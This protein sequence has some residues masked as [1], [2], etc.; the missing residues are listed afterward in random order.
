[1]RLKEPKAWRLLL[2]AAAVTLLALSV[3]CLGAPPAPRSWRF[4]CGTESSAVAK[5]YRRLT[6]A[7]LYSP[8]T[9]FGW[10]K[11]RPAGA[12]VRDLPDLKSFLLYPY[13]IESLDDLNRDSVVST[14]DLTF[15]ID[16]PPGTYRVRL[17]LGDMSRALGSI[18]VTVNGETAAEHVAAWTPGTRGPGNHRRILMDPY[19]WRSEVRHTVHAKQGFIRIEL[20]K[21]QSYYDR[22]LAGQERHEA[23]WNPNWRA[24]YARV[25]VTAPPYFFIGWPFVHHSVMAIEVVP[26]RPA[27]IVKRDGRLDLARTVASPALGEALAAFNGGRYE[28]ALRR[29]EGATEAPARVPRAILELWLAGRLE[30]EDERELV[31]KALA[32]LDPHCDRHP[33]ENGAAEI[34]SDARTFERALRMHRTRGELGKNHFVENAKAIGLWWLVRD[35]SP[36]FDK[37]QLYIARAAHMLLPYFPTRG[38][39]REILRRVE[40]KYPSNRYVRYLLHHQWEPYGDGSRFDDWRMTDYGPKLEGAPAWVRALYPAWAGML[41]WAEWFLGFKQ[42]PDGSIGGG[43]GD[44]VE[45]IGSFGYLGFTSRGVSDLTL[46]GTRKL[47]EGVWNLS[48]V[49]PEIGYCLPLS[50][51]EHTAEWTGNTLGMM[52]QI[53]YGNPKWIERSMK[54]AKLMRDLWTD[55]DRHGRRRFRANYFGG[56][57]VGGGGQQND[58][59]INYRAIRPAAAVLRYNGNPTIARLYVELADAWLASALLTDRGKP[60]GVIPAE[61]SFPDGTPGGAGSPSWY[62]ASHAVDT[63]NEDWAGASAAYKGYLYELFFNAY[64]VTGDAKYFEPLRLEYE[65]AARHGRAPAASGARMEQIPGGRGDGSELV[66]ASWPELASPAAGGARRDSSVEP[67]SEPW[68]ADHLV[69]TQAWLLARQLLEGRRGPLA[70]DITRSDVLRYSEFIYRMLRLR[71]PL[72]TTEASATDRVD[73][74]GSCNAFFIYTGGRWGGAYMEAPVT[75]ENTTRD[76]AAAVL[77][78]DSQGFRL[79]Y[80]SLAPDRR[81]IGVIPWN[82]EPGGRY[83]LRYGPDADENQVMDAVAEER[84][85][86]IARP[87][88]SLPVTVEPRKTYVI[89]VEQ[90][91]RG[92]KPEPAPDP[93]LSSDDIRYDPQHSLILA[94]IHNVGA[95]AVRRVRVA[96][97]DGDPRSGGT[98]IGE[99]VI[100]NIEAPND[101][102]PRT[103]TIGFPWKAAKPELD[104][105]IVV[106]PR[107][108]IP[109]EITTRN[110][111][112]RV[113][114]KIDMKYKKKFLGEA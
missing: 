109:G 31:E 78:S 102:E 3:P 89:E 70:E 81:R 103:V 54:T 22:M 12:E 50:D 58:S 18:D 64:A 14:E 30:V 77:A 99:S 8:R 60:R 62:S 5:G 69:G 21:N 111:V 88:V 55:Y 45:V 33:E 100:P 110:N 39:E 4:D 9:G 13:M 94:R 98:L 32:V 93:A 47:V 46:E 68:V 87:G 112:V 16:V 71:W 59:W 28:D 95:A 56:A 61:V 108:E 10:E 2:A 83:L 19:G 63:G 107:G 101:L 37:S 7:D 34:V 49:D 79:L 51:A 1:M 84:E 105:T 20:K 24:H 57:Q 29:L 40:A 91:A 15:R 11:G 114:L 35:D 73:F 92:R 52:V 23:E 38:T 76:F 65:L 36:L 113:R 85:L 42:A 27:P 86:E 66:V 53:D 44:D 104:V 25:G 82:L 75:Y 72:M 97:Y 41:D 96:A 43:W 74:V 17:T 80:H 67:G 26:H 48:E 106:D 6:A 90:R